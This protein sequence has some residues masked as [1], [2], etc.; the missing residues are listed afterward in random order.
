V[1]D[2]DPTQPVARSDGY[3]Q[4]QQ[5]PPYP[6]AQPGNQPG[7]QIARP[8]AAVPHYGLPASVTLKPGAYVTVR[9]NQGLSSDHNQQGD[10]FTASLEQPIVVDG[11]VVAQRGQTVMGRV[12]QAVKVRG[13]SHS[14]LA[15]QL[16][17]LTLADGSQAN[18]ESQMVNR[19][20]PSMVGSQVGTVAAT[21]ATGAAVG[22]AAAWGTGAAIG[23]G[24][25]AAVGVIGALL[26]PGRPTIVYPESLLTFRLNTPVTVDLTRASAAFRFV[27][28]DEFDRPVQTTVVRRPGP[29]PGPGPGP[30]PAPYYGGGPYYGGPYYGGPGYY[31]YY[32]YSS[33]YGPGFSFGV[34]VRPGYAYGGYRRWR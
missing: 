2:Q 29:G 1:L 21:T 12:T 15:L 22:A 3:G 8:P 11:I 18:V 28:P 30:A 14:S 17:A 34:V 25:G 20:G 7:V 5:Q 23:A 16:T 27:G 32:P 9:M 19:S 4:P 33:W 31:P 10:L 26:T 13:H 24:A 6:G